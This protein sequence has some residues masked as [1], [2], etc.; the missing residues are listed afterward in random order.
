MK[1]AK[2]TKSMTIT[3]EPVAFQRI[4][5][6]TDQEKTSISEWCRKAIYSALV[7]HNYEKEQ[8]NE[9]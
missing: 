7:D 5:E 9:K 6:I 4:K 3:V 8:N 1:T 2:Y